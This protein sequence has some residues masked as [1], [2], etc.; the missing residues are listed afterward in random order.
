MTSEIIKA[1]DED[2]KKAKEDWK[3]VGIDTEEFMKSLMKTLE[4]PVIRSHFIIIYNKWKEEQQIQESLDEIK[5]GKYREIEI[6]DYI[7]EL[8]DENKK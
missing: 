5:A 7:K 6:N 3:A 2:W 1:E 4:D 8:E